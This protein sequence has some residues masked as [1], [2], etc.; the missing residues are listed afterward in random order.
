MTFQLFRL[1]GHSRR[2][3]APFRLDGHLRTHSNTFHN[4]RNSGEIRVKNDA[5]FLN[6]LSQ[7]LKLDDNGTGFSGLNGSQGIQNTEAT[8][9]R[10][11]LQT[12]HLLT[13][14]HILHQNFLSHS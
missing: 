11:G 10:K 9:G 2:Q 14:T 1:L 4:N 5:L 13:V 3:L 12:H 6:L 8:E 7:W